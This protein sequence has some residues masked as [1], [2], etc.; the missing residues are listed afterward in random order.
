MK[1]K[2]FPTR[3]ALV[4]NRLADQA[5]IVV[6]SPRTGKR[7]SMPCFGDTPI[8]VKTLNELQGFGDT[9]IEFTAWELLL[10]KNAWK[11]FQKQEAKECTLA[12]YGPEDC[13]VS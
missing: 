4:D 5:W 1:T 3:V 9:V 13:K 11:R 12:G 2:T 6:V 10:F 7:L 8:I